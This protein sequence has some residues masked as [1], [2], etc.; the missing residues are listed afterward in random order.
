MTP[1]G[2]GW[3]L[4]LLVCAMVVALPGCFGVSQNPSYFPYLCTTGDIIQRTPSPQAP[5]IMP[6]SIPTPFPGGPSAT[7]TNPVRTDLVLVATVYDEK[8]Q[9]RR[10]GRVEW[11]VEG[12]GNL[13]EVDESGC[14]PGPRLEGEQQVRRQLH[15]L[16]RAPHDRAATRNRRTI[17]SCVRAR[18]GAC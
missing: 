4:A 17:S 12:V 2:R 11:M 1:R 5:G 3:C 13:I 8:G 14:W 6:I 10:G 18:A 16:F 15:Q 9:P 7:G